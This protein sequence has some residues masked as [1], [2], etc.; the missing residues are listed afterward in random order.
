MSDRV[1]RRFEKLSSDERKATLEKL[2]ALGGSEKKAPKK[3]DSSSEE[4]S[5]EQPKKGRRE[6][7][8]KDPNAPKRAMNGYLIYSKERRSAA[9]AEYP[10]L[11]PRELSAKM[12]EEW[13]AMTEDQR[14]P[15]N[16]RASGDK[17]R[18]QREKDAYKK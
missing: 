9:K 15:Y 5:E 12:G 17:A 14:R 7:K 4:S 10:S 2:N 16:D 18:Y 11:K 6:R 3:H 13:N 1:I 8:P